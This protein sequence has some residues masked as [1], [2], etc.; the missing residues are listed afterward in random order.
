MKFEESLMI[1]YLKQEAEL[2]KLHILKL[3][4]YR[5]EKQLVEMSKEDVYS[6]RL[7]LEWYRQLIIRWVMD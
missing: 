2:Q 5:E 7:R 1:K 4:R 6:E 3:E